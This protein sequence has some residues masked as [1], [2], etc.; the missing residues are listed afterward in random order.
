M[1][2]SYGGNPSTSTYDAVR[3]YVGDTDSTDPQ[4][5]DGEIDFLMSLEG[6]DTL[7]A[8][9]RGAEALAGKY[10]RDANKKLGMLAMLELEKRAQ[11]YRDLAKQL[12]YS[13]G[14]SSVVPWVG[15]ISQATKQGQQDNED[16]VQPFFTR[17]TMNYPNTMPIGTQEELTE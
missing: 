5:Q 9:A 4:L 2:W 17:T 14:V 3:F 12:W 11:H 7:R 10:A 13:S 1:A 8:A 15:S 16:N 6:N